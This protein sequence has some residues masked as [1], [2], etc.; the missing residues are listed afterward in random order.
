MAPVPVY[1]KG[2]IWSNIEDQ[3]LKAAIQKY[4]TH[5]WSKIASLLQKKSSRQCELRWNEYLNPKLNFKGFT[6][7]E[8]AKLLDLARKLTNQWRTI[9]DMM[10][11]PAQVCIERYNHL[12]AS[13]DDDSE[14][15]LGSSLDFKVG[16]VNPIAETQMAKPDANELAGDEREMLAEARARLLN[17]QGKKATRKIRERMLEESKRIAQ[18]QKRRELKQSGIESKIKKGKKRYATEIDYNEDIVYEKAPASGLYDTTNE[19][20]R[21]KRELER[22][23]TQVNRKGLM[24]NKNDKSGSSDTKNKSKRQNEISLQ[25]IGGPLTGDDNILTNDYKK[26]KLAL[27]A[28]G[29]VDKSIN[30]IVDKR[31]QKLLQNEQIGSVLIG[32]NESRELLPRDIRKGKVPKDRD[33]RSTIILLFAILP[34]PKNDFEIV[35]DDETRDKSEEVESNN[36]ELYSQNSFDQLEDIVDRNII[37]IN[38]DCLNY[39]NLPIP[40]FIENPKSLNEEELNKLVAISINNEKYQD[41]NRLVDYLIEVENQMKNTK[42]KPVTVISN[43]EECSLKELKSTIE[44]KVKI[45]R[46]LKKDME[47]INPLVERNNDLSMEICNKLIPSLRKLQHRY[48]VNYRMYQN[49]LKESTSQ[50]QSFQTHINE[51]NQS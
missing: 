30:E 12:L 24:D 17:T 46:E 33:V 28:P 47:Y 41:D 5:Q 13:N 8:D 25:P 18:L 45:I 48:Y 35:I 31:K 16:D 43:Q 49:E 38:I 44:L 14:F 37:N 23:Q 9:S 50:K 1:V 22:Y 11:R 15:K 29:I 39:T 26:P 3:I 34:E 19:D 51:L 7:E 42:I 6:K 21:M 27:P 10:G 40:D 36:T 2:G 4:G 32:N 20:A